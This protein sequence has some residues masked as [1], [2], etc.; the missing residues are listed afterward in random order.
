MKHKKL[1]SSSSFPE[2][3]LSAELAQVHLTKD[4]HRLR[5]AQTTA[6]D[7][8][9]RQH[10]SVPRDQAP[11]KQ[12]GLPRAWGLPLYLMMLRAGNDPSDPKLLSLAFSSIDGTVP[13][14]Y[15][16]RLFLPICL[17]LRK[18]LI[19]QFMRNSSSKS[20]AWQVNSH[21]LCFSI[22]QLQIYKLILLL[23]ACKIGSMR[24]GLSLM[25]H[26]IKTTTRLPDDCVVSWLLQNEKGGL[27]TSHLFIRSSFTP[28]QSTLM[29]KLLL[30]LPSFRCL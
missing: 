11:L 14:Q 26:I 9:L 22:Q 17:V 8:W 10:C 1:K 12:G 25:D 3:H 2:I 24:L 20:K 27:S 15:V 30:C 28:G 13:T 7:T 21:I 18:T 19:S 29:P 16:S 6:A 4:T 5:A 23:N